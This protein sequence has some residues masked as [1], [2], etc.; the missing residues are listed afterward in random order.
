MATATAN[1]RTTPR[2]ERIYHPL[3]QLRGTIRKYVMIEGVLSVFLFFVAWFTIALVLDYG[4]FKA[5]S[6]DWVQDASFGLRVA[7]LTLALGLLLGIFVFRIARRIMVEFS[8]PALALVLERKFPKLLGDRLITAVE[9]ADETQAEKHGYSV[10]MIRKTI[11]EARE[12]VAQVPVRE[13]FNWRRLRVM[14]I[15]LVAWLVGLVAFGF[16]AHTISAGKFM[17]VHAAWKSYHVASILF[18]RD[19]VLLNTPW[20]RRALLE[21]RD[22][23]EDTVLGEAGIRVAQN[24]GPPRLKVRAYRWVIVDRKNDNGWRP[25]MWSDVT[26]S[27]VGVPVPALPTSSALPADTTKWTVDSIIENETVRGMMSTAM[28]SQNYDQ[29]RAVFDKLEDIAARPSSGRSL[30]KLDQPTE[31]KYKYIGVHTAGD[32]ELKSEGNNEFA[33]EVTGL[34]EDVFFTVRAEDFRSPERNI[35]LIPPPTLMNLMKEEYQPAYLHYASPLIPNPDDPS[36]LIVAGWDA[37]SGLRQRIPDEKLAVTGD[38]TVFVVPV[39]SEVIIKG[40]TARPIVSAFAKPKRGRVPGGKVKIVDGKELRSDEEV[41]LHVET[42]KEKEGDKEFE[43]GKFTMSF[44]GADRVTDIVEFDLDFVNS[45]GIRLTKPWQMQIQVIEDQTPV[46][47]VIPEYLRKVGKEYWA[48]SKAKIPFN[49]E[50]NIRDDSGLS[51]VAY[52]I[53]YEPKDAYVVRSLQF[54]DYCRGIVFPVLNGERGFGNLLVAS[55]NYVFQI[56]SDDANARK[57]ASFPMGQFAAKPN[58]NG[59][60][61]GLD[62]NLKRYTLAH[63]KSMLDK[64]VTEGKP[65]LIKRIGLKTEALMGMRRE[66]GI[67]EKYRWKVDGDYFD[68]GAIKKFQVPPGEVQPRYEMQL[69]VEATDTNYDTGPRIG[70]SDPITILVVSDSELLVKI[71][72]DVSRLATK[73]DETIKKLDGAKVKYEFVRS[74]VDRQLPDELE[75]AKIKAKDA[76]QD[77]QK[78][79]DNAQLVARE[80]RRLERECVYNVMGDKVTAFQGEIANRLE[81]A[82]G[83]NPTPVSELEEKSLAERF[84]RSTFPKVDEL[85]GRGQTEF[86]QGRWIDPATSANTA[87]ELFKLHEEI[88]RIRGVIGEDIGLDGLRNAL[89]NLRDEQAKIN[90]QI[91]EYIRDAEG[92]LLKKTPLLGSAGPFFMAKGETKKVRQSIAWRQYQGDTVKVKVVASDPSIMVPAELTLDFEKNDLN[93]EYEVKTG[94]KEGD[95]TITLTPIV[96]PEVPDKPEPVV[97]QITVK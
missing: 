52:T 69:S 37:L 22:P 60:G 72:E 7:A 47:E 87:S 11:D 53:T 82:L 1:T 50:S 21:L 29:L 19:L 66:D 54:R 76:W 62:A 95:F 14:S 93:F 67:F 46:A 27:L 61:G 55:S 44:R 42:V 64:P 28:G 39:G 56:L 78:S 90:K 45:D 32:G 65:E 35:T 88:V 80:F 15:L 38:R 68:I 23:K 86:D 17:P 94:T 33:G 79:R 24:G 83:E 70:R 58:A 34:K 84:P 6:W 91:E 75:A 26:E 59:E 51:K 81:R 30:R 96:G 63:I 43:R 73:L 4:I 5:T 85:M 92:K 8:H 20:P 10:A 13:V 36:K 16:A 71:G 89:R 97:I 57:E 77:V 40:M 48:T 41:P 3:E 74:K 18:E 25:L 2:D 12:K 49:P 9:L 31:V